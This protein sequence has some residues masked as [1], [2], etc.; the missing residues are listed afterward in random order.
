MEAS[1]TEI[2]RGVDLCI[3]AGEHV[4]VVGPSGAGKSTLVGLLLGWHR[5]ARGEVRVDGRVLD[6]TGLR[7]LRAYTAWV[8]PAVQ[9]WNRTAAENLAYGAGPGPL[10]RLGGAVEAASLGGVVRRLPQ[11]LQTPL[12]EGGALV[13]GGEGQRMRFARAWL[14]R[15]ARLMILD[16]PFR[17]LD[18]ERRHALLGGARR[19]WRGATLLCVT[20]DLSETA[21]FDRVLVVEDG[22]IAEDGAPGELLARPGS[23]Y[24]ALLAAEAEVRARFACGPGWRRIRLQDGVLAEE[25]P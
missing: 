1:G 14:R 23:R 2:L 10:A 13:S 24:A 22:V 4:A 18:R 8:D 6:G 25:A 15:S 5:P 19:A 7:R 17:G 9:L 16:E 21:G 11:G 12:G 3:A 20:H